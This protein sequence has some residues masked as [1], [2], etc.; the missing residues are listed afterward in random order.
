MPELPPLR[1]KVVS[2]NVYDDSLPEAKLRELSTGTG[3]LDRATFQRVKESIRPPY[4]S[5][6]D[7]HLDAPDWLA[8]CRAYRRLIYRPE[9]NFTYRAL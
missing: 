8:L 3:L 5:A 1:H 6:D 7:E 9:F 4:S 2:S